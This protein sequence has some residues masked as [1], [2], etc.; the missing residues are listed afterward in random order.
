MLIIK[1]YG[2]SET[3][4]TQKDIVRQL[5]EASS[6]ELREIDD[7]TREQSDL[8]IAQ[9]ISILDKI[10]RKPSG[11]RCPTKEQ[12]ACRERLGNA[13][14]CRLKKHIKEPCREQA[15]KQWAAKVHPYGAKDNENNKSDFKGR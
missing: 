14:W 2:R 3:K 9:W 11:R 12:W 6:K 5:R 4:P 15:K 1:P 10:I 13:L 8:L 7:Y